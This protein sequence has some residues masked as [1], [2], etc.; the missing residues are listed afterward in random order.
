MVIN[1]T[2][3]GVRVGKNKNGAWTGMCTGRYDAR[4]TTSSKRLSKSVPVA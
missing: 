1:M 3:Q 2:G 4:S